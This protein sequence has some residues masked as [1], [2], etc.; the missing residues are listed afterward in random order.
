MP[1]PSQAK[2]IERAVLLPG[3]LATVIAD[4]SELCEPYEEI[5]HAAD[6]QVATAD[7]A[8]RI[9]ANGQPQRPGLCIVWDPAARSRGYTSK[10]A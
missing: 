2:G 3:G 10:A 7:L 6:S 8:A 1:S 4:S 5:Q 9:R